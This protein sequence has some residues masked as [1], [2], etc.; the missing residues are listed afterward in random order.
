MG[1]GITRDELQDVISD[2][3]NWNSDERE[4]ADVSDKIVR[5]L[6]SHH[7]DLLKIVQASLLDP[8]HAKQASKETWDGMFTKLD[9]YICL[10]HAMGLVPWKT[11]Q[12]IPLDCLYNMDELGNNM[13]KHRKKLWLQKQQ[14]QKL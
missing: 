12:E 10:L 8:K 11:Y 5:G 1:Y 4:F 14:I 3:T 2:V 13:T 9:S 6:F 7:G